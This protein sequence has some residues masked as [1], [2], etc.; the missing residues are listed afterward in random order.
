[1]GGGK[2]TPSSNRQLKNAHLI[3]WGQISN[4][5]PRHLF[6]GAD[7][8]RHEQERHDAFSESEEIDDPPAPSHFLMLPLSEI[9]L[10]MHWRRYLIPL[11]AAG[12]AL[13]L[14]L[15]PRPKQP[16]PFPVKWLCAMIPTRPEQA[17]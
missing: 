8:D 10:K 6:A 4:L 14:F 13:Y 3:I 1:M 9:A 17:P 2:S 16:F 15:K 5:S 12:Q 7:E 11:P